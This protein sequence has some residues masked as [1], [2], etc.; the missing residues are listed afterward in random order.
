MEQRNNVPNPSFEVRNE[1]IEPRD[2]AQILQETAERAGREFDSWP[3]YLLVV[4]AVIFLFAFGAAWLSV[5]QQHPYRGPSD[6]A[7]VVMYGGIL[8]WIIVVSVVVGRATRGVRGPSTRRRKFRSSWVVV[9]FAYSIFQ[10]ALYHAGAT[11][12]IVYGVYP[13]SVPWLFAG[14]VFVTIGVIREEFLAIGLGVALI[15][16]GLVGAFTGPVT[17]WLVSGIGLA[18]ALTSC[19]AVRVV[20]RRS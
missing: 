3:P 20:Q 13:A 6:G 4:G 15:A 10:A 18:I 1:Q 16:V 9:M 5:R 17:S 19:A 12:A 11:R 8:A 7:L 14:T 2:A